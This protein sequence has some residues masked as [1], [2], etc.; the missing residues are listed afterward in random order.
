MTD[1]GTAIRSYEIRL[2]ESCGRVTGNIE[3]S[4]ASVRPALGQVD[5][6]GKKA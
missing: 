3:A 1:A 4:T 6:A 5:S 2:S